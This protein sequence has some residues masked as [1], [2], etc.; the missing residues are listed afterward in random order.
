MR[1]IDNRLKAL[2]DQLCADPM[3]VR[4]SDGSGVEKVGSLDEMIERG[5]IFIKVVSGGGE[6]EARRMLDYVLDC[7][8]KAAYEDIPNE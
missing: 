3:I 4:Y 5:G 8:T 6:E 2:E 7:F 1:S